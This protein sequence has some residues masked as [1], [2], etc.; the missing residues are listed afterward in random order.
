M[1]GNRNHLPNKVRK[2]IWIMKWIIN[3]HF[4]TAMWVIIKTWWVYICVVSP[5]F[6]VYN[7]EKDRSRNLSSSPFTLEKPLSTCSSTPQ[8]HIIPTFELFLVAISNLNLLAKVPE[9]PCD[10]SSVRAAD[11]LAPSWLLSESAIFS[12]RRASAAPR[13]PRPEPRRLLH[14][15]KETDY[16]TFI[17]SNCNAFCIIRIHSSG[18]LG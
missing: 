12:C 18:S 15:Y 8:S 2:L 6:L 3:W 9:A 10:A 7:Y 4:Q 14:A 13:L 17:V 1:N 16:Y 5:T 11:E